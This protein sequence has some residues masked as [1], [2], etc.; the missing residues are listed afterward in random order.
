MMGSM[1]GVKPSPLTCAKWPKSEM[2]L[3]RNF[4]ES[5]IRGFQDQIHLLQLSEHLAA[6]I[7]AAPG[8]IHSG[9]RKDKLRRFASMWEI[10][11]M[12]NQGSRHGLLPSGPKMG[13]SSLLEPRLKQ[14]D[15]GLI[16]EQQVLYDLLNTPAFGVVGGMQLREG[17]VNSRKLVPKAVAD[18]LEFAVNGYASDRT[19]RVYG[20]E[21]GIFNSLSALRAALAFGPSGK[22]S[23]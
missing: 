14:G 9:T 15:S 23:R 1:H 17:S 18:T 3:E 2:S 5:I 8:R 12:Q 7:G 19:G 16:G 22:A 4:A 21:A 10:T 6:K 13:S 20:V 11:Q